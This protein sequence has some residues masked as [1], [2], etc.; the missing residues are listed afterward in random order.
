MPAQPYKVGKT[1][2]VTMVRGWWLQEVHDEPEWFP[3]MGSLHEDREVFGLD[4]LHYHVDPRFLDDRLVKR[5]AA[6][7]ERDRRLGAFNGSWHPSY[8]RVM[9][10]FP[11]AKRAHYIAVDNR[12]AYV[13]EKAYGTTVA[14]H[15]RQWGSRGS[16]HAAASCSAAASCRA[17]T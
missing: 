12:N 7:F 8:R 6:D 4:A 15:P 16:R 9:T 14:A 3:V 1:Y 11:T 5:V 2:R 13:V 10:N 17:S